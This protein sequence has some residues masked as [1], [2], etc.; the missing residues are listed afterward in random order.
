[1]SAVI[2]TPPSLQACLEVT[3]ELGAAL[4]ALRE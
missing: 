3:D 4:A 1:V 2:K